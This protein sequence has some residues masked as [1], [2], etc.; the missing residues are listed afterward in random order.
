MSVLKYVTVVGGDDGGALQGSISV[1]ASILVR[2][3]PQTTQKMRGQ[4]EEAKK[5]TLSTL[6]H[7]PLPAPFLIQVTSSRLYFIS[8]LSLLW[9]RETN[10]DNARGKLEREKCNN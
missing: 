5:M 2:S 9:A 10:R 3:N 1:L 4:R 8:T 7:F 6:S